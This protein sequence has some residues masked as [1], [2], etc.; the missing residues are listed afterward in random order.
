MSIPRYDAYPQPRRGAKWLRWFAVLTPLATAIMFATAW[1]DWGSTFAALMAKTIQLEFLVIHAGMFLGVLILVQFESALV[2]ALR[3]VAVIMLTLMY[4][5][6]GYG[7]LGWNG[8]LTLVAVFVGTYAGFIPARFGATGGEFPFGKRVTELA[9]RWLMSMLAFGLLIRPFALPQLMNT[10][11]DL[12]AS[13]A[14]GAVYFMVLAM[15]EATPL[16]PSI[17][18]ERRAKK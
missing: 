12:R 11:T 14:L 18:G 13:V 3:W 8:V 16:Y 1:L 17:R 4:C 15:L 2:R 6:G 7:L 10:W 5:Y 9:V